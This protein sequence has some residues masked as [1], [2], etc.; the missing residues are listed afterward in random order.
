MRDV[1]DAFLLT[2]AEVSATLIGLFLVGAFYYAEIGLRRLGAARGSFEP[3]LRAGIRITL[4]VL[5]LPLV[6]SLTLVTMEPGWNRLLFLVL[7]AVTIVAN[8]DTA[9]RIREVWAATRS[10]VLLG[11]EVLTTA[12]VVVLVVLPW[13][14]GGLE[15]TREHLTWAI[16]IA[17]AAGLLSIGATVMSVFDLTGAGLDGTEDGAGRRATVKA[18][19]GAGD[20]TVATKRQRP[21][22]SR[23]AGKRGSSSGGASPGGASPGGASPV[24]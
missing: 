24:R 16:L 22:R 20:P 15:P 5:A 11:M 21:S 3:Y 4:I 14:L 6:L 13:A 10:A 1:S 2:V 23:V 12:G 19:S 7:S 9:R 8:I 18:A 17:L